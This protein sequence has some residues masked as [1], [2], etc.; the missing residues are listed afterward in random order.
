[1][2]FLRTLLKTPISTPK[3]SLLWE[4]GTLSISALIVMRKLNFYH[5]IMNLH[6]DALAKRF[7]IIQLRNKFPGLMKEAKEIL[8]KYALDVMEVE[9]FSKQSWKKMVKQ[10]VSRVEKEDLLNKIK[11]YK[12]VNYEEKVL[13][14]FGL[15]EYLRKM[16][17]HKARMKFSLETEMT[18]T[19]KFN[20][21]NDKENER[22]NWACDYCKK[23]KNQYKP[24]SIKHA[25][26]CEEYENLR[27]KYDLS[28]EDDT[29]NYFTKIVEARNQLTIS[30]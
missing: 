11:Q 20:Y 22:L 27:E 25:M 19:F 4:T 17:L 1:M 9:D 30:V 12:K 10:R 16:N 15:K 14:E 13:E 8:R 23:K 6:E 24:D 29:V 28:C 26:E 18:R 21:M 3:A 5:H 2:T 7:A